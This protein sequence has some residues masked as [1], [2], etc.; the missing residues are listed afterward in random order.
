MKIPIYQVDAFA[1]QLFKGNPAAICPINEWL[2][3]ETM[4]N[5]GLENNLS[6]TAFIVKGGNDYHI[7][8][9]TPLAEVELC[10]HATLAAAHVVFNHLNHTSNNITFHSKSGPLQVNRQDNGLITLHFPN[11]NPEKIND[12]PPGMHEGL[13]VDNSC[14]VFKTSFDYMVVLPSQNAVE[15][16]RPDFK[17]LSKT[18]CRGII[19]TA[20]GNDVD[21]VSRCFYPRTGVDED[22]VTGSAHTIMVPYWAAQLNKT[23]M[24]AVQLSKRGGQL[25]VELLGNRVLMSGHA[26]TYIVGEVIIDEQ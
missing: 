6:E 4:Q 15:A 14:P 11:N 17:L 24:K 5:M 21:F 9:F 16:L 19:T 10:G 7:R 25:D 22:P 8:W 23:K 12:I 1:D 13:G 26:I 3:D 18:P 20:R 2:S